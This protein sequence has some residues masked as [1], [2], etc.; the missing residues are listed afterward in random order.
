MPLGSSS[1]AVENGHP[2]VEEESVV[3]ASLWLRLSAVAIDTAVITAAVL[4]SGLLL[5]LAA[6]QAGWLTTAAASTPADLTSEW[7]TLAM[8][9]RMLVVCIF[10]LTGGGIYYPL[11]H[12]SPAQATLGKR[13]MRIVVTDTRGD[14]LSLLRAMARNLLK[15]V[16]HYGGYLLV[17]SILGVLL[18][19]KKQ[20]FHDLLTRT[21]VVR[22]STSARIGQEGWR[23]AVALGA[24]LPLM[25]VL[26]ALV[27]ATDQ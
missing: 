9:E 8:P 6:Q 13:L 11:L 15:F 10:Y 7:L 17:V 23:L 3:Y 20:A 21:V 5:R 18:A 24:P 2:F 1:N 25:G 22:G 14:P 4:S 27:L 12:S 16:L 19:E 26:V